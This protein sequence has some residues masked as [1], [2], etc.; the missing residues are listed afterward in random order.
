VTQ[1]PIQETKSAVAFTGKAAVMM[2]RAVTTVVFVIAGLTFCFGFGNG[3]AVGMMLG[4]PGWIAPL[5][6]PAI[7]LSVVALLASLQ[8]L[9]ANGAEGRLTAPRLLLLFSGVATLA[10]NTA[11]PI[12]IG[13]YG[14]ACF[15]A[16]APLLLI[17]WSEVGP[18]LLASLH[19]TT[20]GPSAVVPDG[21]AGGDAELVARARQLD[22]EHREVHGRPI[23][24]DK[25]RAAL[26]VSNAVASEVLR[27]VRTTTKKT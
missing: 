9:R 11:H 12:I 6:A 25:L 20:A 27:Q 24:R 13:Q 15:Y 1:R 5:V 7:D 17:G 10:M 26:K 23:T 2:R 8:Y 4:V 14:Q 18:R 21:Q 3:Y 22:A 19:G 16:V